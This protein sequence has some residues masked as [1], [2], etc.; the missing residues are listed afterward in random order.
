[1][2]LSSKYATALLLIAV[3]VMAS[4]ASINSDNSEADSR[5]KRQWGGNYGGWGGYPYGSDGGW[6]YGGG[7]R[8]NRR[9]NGGWG[10]NQGWNGGWGGN[11]GWWHG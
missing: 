8:W 6:P 4:T 7:G 5:V 10:G 9:W 11:G 3:V 2:S 1:M